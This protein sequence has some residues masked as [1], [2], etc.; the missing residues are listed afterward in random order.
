MRW[1]TL[2][3]SFGWEMHENGRRIQLERLEHVRPLVEVDHRKEQAVRVE[4][5]VAV[6][7][8]DDGVLV[9]SMSADDALSGRLQC[10]EHYDHGVVAR[11]C[12]NEVG[13]LVA[14]EPEE[15][16]LDVHV[17]QLLHP[18]RQLQRLPKKIDSR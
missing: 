16:L 5:R 17:E 7:V 18:V 10:G 1:L 9:V 6:R 8:R 13:E 14:V 3:P 12:H 4:L 11:S 2:R 15:R